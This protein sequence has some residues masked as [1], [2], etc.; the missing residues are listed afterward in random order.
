MARSSFY[1]GGLAPSL[2]IDHASRHRPGVGELGYS[3]PVAFKLDLPE[4][5]RLHNIFHMS[6]FK[7]YLRG[8]N[9]QPPPMPTIVDGEE[10]FNVDQILNHRDLE[11]TVRC[12][13][14]HKPA[15]TTYV[16]T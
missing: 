6:L 8:A 13:T 3:M 12:A 10:W 2:I 14:K 16:A 1:Q 4:N 9:V 5:M 11:V 7:P 15:K